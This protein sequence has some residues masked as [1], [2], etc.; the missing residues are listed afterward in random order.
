MEREVIPQC[1]EAS[2]TPHQPAHVSIADIVHQLEK[3]V[4]GFLDVHLID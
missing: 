3:L 1:V 2:F 4:K